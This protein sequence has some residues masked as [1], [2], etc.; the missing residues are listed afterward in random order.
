MTESEEKI[1]REDTLLLQCS[2]FSEF[3]TATNLV[4]NRKPGMATTAE[5]QGIIAGLTS[6]VKQQA[7]AQKVTNAQITQLTEA[8]HAYG[9]PT[10]APATSQLNS[11]SLRMP[12]L[13]LP[14]FRYDHNTHDDVN[15]FLQT[16]DVQTAH[17]QVKT[18]LTLLQQSC[19]GEWPTSVLSMEETKFTEETTASQKLDNLKHALKAS[20]AEPPDVQR[21]RLASEFSTMK[22]RATESIDLFAFRFKNNLHRLAKLGEPVDSTSPHF[23][24]SQFVS[25]TKTDVQKHLVLKAEEYKDLSEIIEATKRIERSFSP[26]SH[27]PPNKLSLDAPKALNVHV[28]PRPSTRPP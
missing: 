23:I 15:E 28:T 3:L 8:L 26:G 11:A 6:I 21:R 4:E 22:Q 16:F 25:K 17:L 19:I 9:A 12:S 10:T 13:Q 7:D 2:V 18:K 20:F 14:K 27:S 24:M 5:L 1:K